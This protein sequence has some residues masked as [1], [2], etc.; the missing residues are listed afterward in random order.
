[1]RR[2]LR[3]SAGMSIRNLLDTAQAAFINSSI[4]ERA[5]GRG[6]WDGGGR[7]GAPHVEISATLCGIALGH[8]GAHVLQPAQ[9]RRTPALPEQGGHGDRVACGCALVLVRL[10]CPD[11]W[12]SQPPDGPWPILAGGQGYAMLATCA[13]RGASVAGPC[14]PVDRGEHAEA[15]T[16]Y[17]ARGRGRVVLD[18]LAIPSLPGGQWE[19]ND[20]L[21]ESPAC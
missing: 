16:A 1:M 12:Q 18:A 5:G 7:G 6:A 9:V 4:I 21:P 2:S 3:I 20:S 11:L 15:G 10:V 14:E 13:G 19:I 17:V 8:A